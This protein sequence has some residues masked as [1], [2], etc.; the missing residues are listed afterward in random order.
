MHKTDQNVCIRK[1]T[2]QDA[3]L[4]TQIEAACFPAAEA[5]TRDRF[6]ARLEAFAD[7]FLICEV[8]GEA[9]GFIDGMVIDSP[10]IEDV[11]FEK[12]D[13][14]CPDGAWQ[15]IF[16]LNTLPKYRR[17]GYAAR[18]MQA[19]IAQAREE[20]RRGL[21]LTCKE[22]MLHYYAKF[23][24]VPLGASDSQHGG[25]RWFDMVLEFKPEIAM[26]PPVKAV[27]FDLDGTLV[28]S[29]PMLTAA[30]NRVMR[31]NGC[32]EFTEAQI[33]A[34][35]GRG[36][37][38]LIESV[39]AAQGIEPTPE[40]VQRFLQAYVAAMMGSGL[41]EEKFYPGAREAVA[42]LQAAGFKTALVTNKMRMVTETFVQRSGLNADLD[43]LVA[44]DD[45]DH[46]KPAPDMLLLACEK[47]GVSPTEAVM[48]GDS[49][50]DAWAAKAAGIRAMLVSTG[51][52]GTVP[53]TQWAKDNGFSLVF[54]SVAGIKDYIF[55]C[56]G[57]FVS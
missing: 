25:A 10:Y 51:Y 37:K 47:L 14:H 52:N 41:P 1:A 2:L 50:N 23:G 38:A 24:F 39:C 21:T 13:R 31:A 28:D 19:L 4:L 46:P 26:Q 34:M 33:A 11:M 55:A 12:A 9:V 43:V 20:G 30:V 7:H 56:E 16:G 44:G 17:R 57:K 40:N 27:L 53:M 54:D 22:H 36:A 6:D 49:E 3:A 18:L 15:S 48:V 45:T 29:V 5:A 32:P 42:A 8:D 35:V